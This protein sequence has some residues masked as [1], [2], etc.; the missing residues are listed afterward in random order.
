MLIKA[1]KFS[2]RM[3]LREK[4]KMVTRKQKKFQEQPQKYPQKPEQKPKPPVNFTNMPQTFQIGGQ[5]YPN[6]AAFEQAGLQKE[7]AA[8]KKQQEYKQLLQKADLVTAA[9]RI[10]AIEQKP[11]VEQAQIPTEQTQIAQI[12]TAQ[13]IPSAPINSI[14]DLLGFSTNIETGGLVGGAV[15]QAQRLLNPETRQEEIGRVGAGVLAGATIGTIGTSG[16]G[17]FTGPRLISGLARLAFAGGATQIPRVILA[18][19][20]SILSKSMTDMSTQITNLNKGLVD[21][22]TARLSFDIDEQ[23]ILSAESSIKAITTNKIL[24]FISGG[25]DTAVAFEIAKRQIPALRRQLE[26]ARLRQ[27]AGRQILQQLT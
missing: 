7:F 2:L 3:Q 13:Q 5:Q 14:A 12:P 17:G 18:T 22:S 20:Q 11:I 6:A 10:A 26:E 16:V 8:G 21:Y 9:E 19:H 24:S 23:N 25:K 1:W 15:N 4:D 27:E